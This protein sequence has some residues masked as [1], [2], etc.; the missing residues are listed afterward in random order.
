MRQA[1]PLVL[2]LATFSLA[3]GIVLPLVRVEQLLVFSDEP[4][5]VEL[6][7]G[8]WREGDRLLAAIVG[9]FSIVFPCTKLGL[10]H[11]AAYR[12]GEDGGLRVPGWV[13]GMAKWSML[14]VLLVAL[15]IFAAKTSGLATA[16]AMPGL[17]F[18]AASAGLTAAASWLASRP[19]GTSDIEG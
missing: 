19:A 9:L 4:S 7:A 2:F 10:L 16:F 6:I 12:G 8:L 5:L 11:L 18:F 14:D 1:F 15:V 3:I 17:W 13:S